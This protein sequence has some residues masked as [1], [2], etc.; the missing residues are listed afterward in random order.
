[1]NLQSIKQGS[2]KSCGCKGIIRQEKIKKEKIIPVDNEEEQWKECASYS[3]YYIST[4]GRLYNYNIQ[5]IFPIKTRYKIKSEEFSA[6]KEMYRTFVGEYDTS[7]YT[8]I[9][10]SKNVYALKENKGER[11]KKLK[12]LYGSI[13]TRCNNQNNKDY[14]NY[15][16]RGIKID[17]SF[18]TLDKFVEWAISVNFECGKSLEIDRKDN[19]GDYSKDNC[20]FVTKADNNRNQRRTKFS[21]EIVDDIRTGKYKDISNVELGKM[22][23]VSH[24]NIKN[25]RTFKSWNYENVTYT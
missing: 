13:K 24:T 19:N 3:G 25:I 10:V 9:L 18:S 20:R 6:I 16:G 1:M 2:S 17:D 22:F 14:K 15:G 4:L 21:I 7:L 11:Y 5:Y 8:P 12:A 23:N